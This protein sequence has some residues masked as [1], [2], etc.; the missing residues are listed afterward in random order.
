[1][2]NFIRFFY[3]GPGVVLVVVGIVIAVAWA[4]RQSQDRQAALE[5]KRQVTRPLGS[6]AAKD[7]VDASQAPKESLLANGHLTGIQAQPEAEQIPNAPVA[8]GPQRQAALPTL[9]SFYSQVSSPAPTPTPAPERPKAPEIWLPRGTLIPAVLVIT[10]ESSHINTPVV[11]EVTRDVYQKCDGITR[12]IIPAGTIAT[13]FAE[14]GAVRDRIEVAGRWSLVYPD[15]KEF[16]LTAIALDREADPSNQQFGIEDGSAGLQGQLVESD[17]WANAKA[18]LALLM[19]ATTQT[20][21]ALASGA[22]SSSRVGG[23]V[24]LPDT[25]AIQAKYLDQL[26]NGETGDGR[27]VRVCAG[28]ECY[29]FPTTVVE[30]TKRSIGARQQEATQGPV[31]AS[32]RASSNPT[33]SALQLEQ[34]ALKAIQPQASPTPERIHF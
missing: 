3:R 8:S 29:I 11:C 7:S 16:E 19:T 30:P 5:A 33:D 17:H 12:L 10:V 13:C 32:N 27:F 20:G 18:F 22:L 23:A 26:L 6:V 31:V 25:S 14:A 1:M 9:V 21:T 24:V 28:K 4:V 15:G 2:R 34:E